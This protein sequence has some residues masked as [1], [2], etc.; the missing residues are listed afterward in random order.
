MADN[1]A[2]RVRCVGCGAGLG[3]EEW[4]KGLDACS[5]CSAK[6]RRGIEV[7]VPGPAAASISVASPALQADEFAR[8]LD[9]L[10]APNSLKN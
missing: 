9:E 10:P 6:A 1:V 7:Y 5:S 8:L 3:F 4:P 2:V